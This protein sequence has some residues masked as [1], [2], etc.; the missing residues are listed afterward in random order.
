[1][2]LAG[3]N[4]ADLPV[5]KRHLLYTGSLLALSVYYLNYGGVFDEGSTE[6]VGMQTLLVRVVAVSCIVTAL[7]PFRLRS[8]SSIVIQA[9]YIYGA[10]S[11]VLAA[12]WY[13]PLNDSFFLNTIIQLPVLLALVGTRCEIDYVRW[14]KLIFW[15]LGIQVVIDILIL[16]TGHSLW[17]SKAFVGGLGNPSSFGLL[18]V[19][20]GTFCIFH[21]SVGR[22][23]WILV[24]MLT[25]G[26]YQSKAVF[27]VLTI[28]MLFM[29][30]ISTSWKRTI[31]ASIVGF[32]LAL[33]SVL[34]SNGQSDDGETGYV[35][36]KLMAVGALLSL[37]EYD[38][39]SSASVSQRIAMHK[40]TFGELAVDPV[41]LVAGHLKG[42]P[43]WAMDS[44]LLT[45]L[46][47]FGAPFLMLFLTLHVYWMV[48]AW[49]RRQE[50]NGFTFLCLCIFGLI[51]TTNRILDYFPIAIIYFMI[52]AMTL[53]RGAQI[54]SQKL[55][56][57]ATPVPES[58]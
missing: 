40:S 15:V 21:P 19:L 46:G 41:A 48:C 47:S 58:A 8:W 33:G 49:R 55:R 7:F 10:L 11:F 16:Q 31:C 12:G 43:Y 23:R 39:D 22:E 20:G 38:V 27:A 35:E 51:F 17:L 52:I 4:N 45:Y 32:L 53:K 14:L 24:I 50:D 57:G 26:A 36:H 3:F 42:L 54:R 29:V 9:L 56:L 2:A 13:G 25:I 18:C 6:G 5:W 1:M 28:A 44:Q 30:W 34:L 37:V